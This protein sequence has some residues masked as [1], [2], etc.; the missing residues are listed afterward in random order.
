MI[1][2]NKRLE[3]KNTYDTPARSYAYIYREIVFT[4]FTPHF[5]KNMK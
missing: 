4:L 3:R 1:D 2:K 5:L